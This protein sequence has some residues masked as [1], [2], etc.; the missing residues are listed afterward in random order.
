MYKE[1][2]HSL[3]GGKVFQVPDYQRGYAWEEKQWSDLVEDIDAL[4]VDGRISSH[5]TGTVVTYTPKQSKLT[6]D[7]EEAEMV[8]VVDGQQR[9]TTVSLFLS[10]II[11]T[12]VKSGEKGYD[13]KVADFLYDKNMT[14]LKLN[15]DT[16]DIFIEL[17]KSGKP[18]KEP[19]TVHQKRLC[20]AVEHFRSYVQRQLKDTNRGI[21]HI[22]ELFKAI[23]GK[24]TFTYYSI[25][26]ECEI[27]MTFELMNSR[28]KDLSVLELIKNYFMHWISRNVSDE[29]REG[30]TNIV[31]R[32]WR[33]V[34]ANIGSSTGSEEQC[35]RIA[36]TLY[37]HHLP[38]H[39]KGYNGFKTREQIPLRDFSIKPIEEVKKFLINFTNG[40][41]EL[42]KHYGIIITPDSRTTRTTA[43]Y[44]WLSR[45]HNAGNV[46][47]FLPLLVAARI[48]REKSSI[49][50]E[51]YIEMLKAL[52]IYA[53]R[54]FLVEG[55]RSNSGRST[56]FR[57]GKEL[58]KEEDTVES[59]ID[60]IYGYVRYYAPEERFRDFIKT[61]FNWYGK[62]H[63][64]RYTLFEY[65]QYLLDSES[66][67][68]QPIITWKDLHV[69]TTL[70]HVL[71]QTLKEK[72]HWRKVWET[73]SIEQYLHD[74]GNISLTRDNS[75]YSNF[76]FARKKSSIG[77]GAC[78]SDS[79]IRQERALAVYDDW[80]PDVLLER[81]EKIAK[82]I[83]ERWQCLDKNVPT[84]INEDEDEDF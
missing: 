51:M 80:T 60:Q 13:S 53:Y 29:E 54:V 79:D 37:C 4:V 57:L 50:E 14:K 61:P 45:I 11:R 67:G 62:R 25:E 84:E 7:L 83:L 46:A 2:L 27:G 59:I 58:F 3:F 15:N 18:R 56:L 82:W 44:R 5:Y 73:K 20:Q 39:W 69:E 38:K 16:S 23:T 81:R 21:G 66:H 48:G 24:M 75:V 42:S 30:H 35:L 36:W 71:P 31:N 32:A 34:Y 74:I 40:L 52:E 49:T 33:D 72:S 76:E 77:E 65:E 6:Y 78:Y 70:E 64:L 28:G 12:L 26:E 41:A 63:L 10:E 8:D 68:Q 19:S 47:N 9:L 43:E 55:K 17:I 1:T 22:E